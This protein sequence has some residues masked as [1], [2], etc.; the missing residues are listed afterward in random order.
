MVALVFDFDRSLVS[1]DDTDRHVPMLLAPDLVP[2]MEAQYAGGRRWTELMAEIAVRLHERGVSRTAI[3][4]ALCTMH[5][6]A[7]FIAAIRDAKAAGASVHVLSDANRV[8]I[9]TILVHYHLDALFD[10]VITNP[11]YFAPATPTPTGRHEQLLVIEPLTPYATPHG[12][13]RCPPNMCKGGE[14]DRMRLSAAARSGGAASTLV[15]VGDGTGD[16]CPCLR[17]GE[18]DVICARKGYPLARKL[19]QADI[20]PLVR[21]RVVEWVSGADVRAVVTALLAAAPS[22]A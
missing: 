9:D 8:S 12:C 1:E 20:R 16:L 15:Y 5:I 17:L 4:G 11:A 7:G 14:L 19:A 3:E 13:H 10:S 22:P 18:A 21:A 2:Y 6:H